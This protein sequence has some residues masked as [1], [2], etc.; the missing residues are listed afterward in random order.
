MKPSRDDLTVKFIISGTTSVMHKNLGR[1]QS[2]RQ[3]RGYEC[4]RYDKTKITKPATYTRQIKKKV[5]GHDKQNR[6]KMPVRGER[7][8]F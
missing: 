8:A 2:G 6:I 3:S 7:E 1:L 5:Q 4:D